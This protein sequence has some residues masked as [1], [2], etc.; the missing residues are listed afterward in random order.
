MT[1]YEVVSDLFIERLVLL[2]NH[3]VHLEGEMWNLTG[4][5]TR[6]WMM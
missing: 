4:I 3:L 5:A 6:Y 1:Q 2:L